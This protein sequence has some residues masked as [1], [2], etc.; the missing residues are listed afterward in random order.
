MTMKQR[1]ARAFDR[2]G[3]WC[4]DVSMK[5]DPLDVSPVSL[6]PVANTITAPPERIP[7]LTQTEQTA[8]QLVEAL[9]KPV[10]MVPGWAMYDRQCLMV[11]NAPRVELKAENLR[12]LCDA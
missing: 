9:N 2:L 3:A 1:L 10:F 12:V 5:L 6:P 7:P 8:V 4:F 11:Q